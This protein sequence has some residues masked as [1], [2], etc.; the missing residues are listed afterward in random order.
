MLKCGKTESMNC[1]RN[2]T[3]SWMALQT[4][5]KGDT[6][7]SPLKRVGVKSTQTRKSRLLSHTSPLPLISLSHN[8]DVLALPDK[9]W[10]FK[11]KCHLLVKKL[12]YVFHS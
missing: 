10:S 6:L 11:L 3:A 8:S 2:D 5:T 4:Q 1:T 9:N 12:S 7:S